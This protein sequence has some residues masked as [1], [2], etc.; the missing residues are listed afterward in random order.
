MLRVS[1]AAISQ[2]QQFFVLSSAHF[3]AVR[4]QVCSKCRLEVDLKCF[5]FSPGWQPVWTTATAADCLLALDDFFWLTCSLSD[6]Y[7][8][9]AITAAKEIYMG[10]AVTFAVFYAIPI[11]AETRAT[12]SALFI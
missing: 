8:C 1:E 12:S 3:S 9:Q 10:F 5:F 11:S 7:G 2:E 4:H 6:L